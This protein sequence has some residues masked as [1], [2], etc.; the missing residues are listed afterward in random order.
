MTYGAIKYFEHIKSW[1]L[2]QYQVFKYSHNTQYYTVTSC[3][4][5]SKMVQIT[6]LKNEIQYFCLKWPKEQTIQYFIS[7]IRMKKFIKV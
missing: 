2:Q 7:Q 6:N 3:V 1:I 5:S 4:R